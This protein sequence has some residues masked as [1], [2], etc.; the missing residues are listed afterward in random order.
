MI[1]SISHLSDCW[2]ADLQRS[3]FSAVQRRRGGRVRTHDSRRLIGRIAT[4]RG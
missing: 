3:S 2:K 4:V 1:S